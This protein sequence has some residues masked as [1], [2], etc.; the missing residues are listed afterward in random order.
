MFID[1]S[2][3]TS[4][5]SFSDLPIEPKVGLP[6]SS[7][8]IPKNKESRLMRQNEI[9]GLHKP[10]SCEGVDTVQR[11]IHRA[12]ENKPNKLQTLDPLHQQINANMNWDYLGM[13]AREGFHPFQNPK[14]LPPTKSKT[15]VD[16]KDYRREF[17]LPFALTDQNLESGISKGTMQISKE[18]FTG[19]TIRQA[20]GELS[21]KASSPLSVIPEFYINSMTN[22]EPSFAGSPLSAIG[23]QEETETASIDTNVDIIDLL[24]K[25]SAFMQFCQ[26]RRDFET[27]SNHQG[28]NPMS[29]GS[30]QHLRLALSQKGSSGVQDNVQTK[31]SQKQSHLSTNIFLQNTASQTC[32]PIDLPSPS[33][34]RSDNKSN[35]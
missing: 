5:S 15:S 30:I 8:L 21:S 28:G 10:S 6:R 14:I 34:F 19:Q 4:L 29:Q 24:N 3:K 20:N 33:T 2:D 16:Q 9:S 12:I 18:D 26:Q 7:Q 17:I 23:R 32:S 25:N 35:D 22:I 13:K 31:S 1:K 11:Q 27:A